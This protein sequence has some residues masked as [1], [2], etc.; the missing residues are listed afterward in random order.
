MSSLWYNQLKNHFFAMNKFYRFKKFCRFIATS[1]M[2]RLALI[3]WHKC[4][5][6]LKIEKWERIYYFP[7]ELKIIFG[8]FVMYGNYFYSENQRQ[9]EWKYA[10]K[11]LWYIYIGREPLTNSVPYHPMVWHVNIYVTPM[12][13]PMERRKKLFWHFYLWKIGMN[14]D[15]HFVCLK[16]WKYKNS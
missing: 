5:K 1:L 3:A 13:L 6:T 12:S 14:S 7:T 15:I 9:N 8:Y 10:F 11:N 4:F 2:Q 16:L